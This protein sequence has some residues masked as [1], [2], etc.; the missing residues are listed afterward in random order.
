MVAKQQRKDKNAM[1]AK[2][3][4]VNELYKLIQNKTV[5]HL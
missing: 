4:N 2:E 3:Q 5:N 1:I